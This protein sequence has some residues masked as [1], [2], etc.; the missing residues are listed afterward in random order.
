M[1]NQA[2]NPCNRPTFEAAIALLKVIAPANEYSIER[3]ALDYGAGMWWETIICTR[4]HK[5]FDSY[6][7]L[8]PRDWDA[9]AIAD[10]PTEIAK[11][12]ESLAAGQK[13]LLGITAAPAP[14]PRIQDSPRYCIFE[15]HICSHAHKDGPAFECKATSDAE[16]TCRR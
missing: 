15:K 11:L 16:M 13:N 7:M 4:P 9:L 5:S 10:S 12:V 8:N 1:P 14:A 3:I 2:E 6:Q